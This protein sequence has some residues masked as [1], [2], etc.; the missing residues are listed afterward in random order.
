MSYDEE[1]ERLLESFSVDKIY[2][3]TIY[4]DSWTKH[5]YKCNEFGGTNASYQ[6]NF[7]KTVEANPPSPNPCFPN[8][9]T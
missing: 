7:E 3:V 4:C 6:N 8:Y 9:E 5:D 2:L 1:E